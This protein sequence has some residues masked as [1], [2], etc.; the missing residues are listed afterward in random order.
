MRL[1]H[2]VHPWFLLIS[3]LAFQTGCQKTVPANNPVSRNS[4]QMILVVTSDFDQPHGTLRRFQRED[5]SIWQPVGSEV[6]V[7]VGRNGLAWG[8]GLHSSQIAGPQKKEGDGKSP[9]GIF[10]L[11]AV[12]G[13]A[14]PEEASALK[15]PYIQITETLE[16]IDDT[17]SKFYNLV[18]DRDA[19][20]EVD[21]RS[22]E[23][24]HE[25]A[26]YHLGV[27]IDHNANQT[28]GGGSCIFLHIWDGP[29][30]AT[31]GCTAMQSD[32]LETIVN[33]LDAESDPILVQLPEPEYFRLLRDWQLP[34]F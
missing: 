19:V 10:Q 34:Q 15:M 26:Q 11:S 17:Q 20:P 7:V 4:H 16:C 3:I 9:A 29:E 30:S 1:R 23:K 31:S 25:I 5:A 32:P 22:S 24:M 21:W 2:P 8:S 27:T 18:R 33:W 28:P 6:A 13:F 12:F 14:P